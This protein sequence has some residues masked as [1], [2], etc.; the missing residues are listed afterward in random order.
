MEPPPRPPGAPRGEVV[1]ANW[2]SPP[3]HQTPGG[4]DSPV[5]L[6]GLLP[7]VSW[8]VLL[9]TG[10]MTVPAV[11][12]P[13]CTWHSPSSSLKTTDSQKRRARPAFPRG[14]SSTGRGVQ[15]LGRF[16]TAT[17]PAHPLPELPPAPLHRPWQR[18]VRLRHGR[19]H[20][21]WMCHCARTIWK[22]SS[23]VGGQ[24]GCLHDARPYHQIPK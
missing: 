10:S 13:D 6:V 17:H 24:W 23:F 20:F 22:M 5:T 16:Q 14:R 21:S 11:F 19:W 4:K 18:G 9:K 1:G 3:D 12:D 7:E 2:T 8:Q 15:R